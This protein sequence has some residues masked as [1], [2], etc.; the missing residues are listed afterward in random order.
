M[1]NNLA[2]R[3]QM[4]L[5]DAFTFFVGHFRQIATM[6]L[7]F[8]FG[9]ALFQ[10]VLEQA[11]PGSPMAFLA[12]VALGAV[13]Y[14]IYMAALIKLMAGRARQEQ[15]TSSALITAAIPQWSRLLTL[16]IVASFMILV[17]FSLL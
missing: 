16:K 13:I 12:S 5:T 7:P 1:P 9:V 15:P 17:G 4:I 8:L 11:Y 14:P 10:V 3:I 6:C 2:A